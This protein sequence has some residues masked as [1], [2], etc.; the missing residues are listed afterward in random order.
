MSDRFLKFIPSDEALYLARKHPKA[1]ILLVFIAERARR[2]NGHPDG[3]TIGQC[4]IG[5]FKSYGLTEKEYRTAKKILVQRNHIKIVETCRS[6]K[7]EKDHS[8]FFNLQNPE[9]RATERATEVTTIGTL[10]ELCSSSIY[11]I[12]SD[13][14]NQQKGDRKGDRGAT[15]GRP[16]GEE[17]E[18]KRKKKKEK[19]EQQPLSPSFSEKVK[20][21][22][23]VQ[24]TQIE[25]DSLLAKHG[26]DFF[27]RMLDALDSYKGSSGKSYKSDFHTMKEG[28]W[29]IEKLKKEELNGHIFSSKDTKANEIFAQKLEQKYC[30][31]NQGWRCRIYNDPK[32]DQKGL[33]FESQSPYVAPHF[34]AFS[35]GKF[36]EEVLNFLKLK[37][38]GKNLPLQASEK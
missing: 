12:N 25:F 38:I 4:H 27:D 14:R 10:V 30:D 20:F 16:K 17:Q 28:G 2:E 9:N 3:L 18:G 35:S 23:N 11:D 1:F 36:R 5:D 29:V 8:L 13:I 19:E 6:R 33:L 32:K 21:R 22:E 7:K 34:F 26:K 31:Y 24:L 15:E 37:G